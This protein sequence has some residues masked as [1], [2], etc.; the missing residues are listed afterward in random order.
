M[1]LNVLV[2]DVEGTLAETDDVHRAAFNQAFAEARLDWV[3]GRVLYRQLRAQSMPG[4]EV[5]RYVRL[6][7]ADQFDTL[8]ASG[9][10]VDLVQRQRQIYQSLIDAGAAPLRPGV[11]RLMAEALSERVRLAICATTPRIEFVSLIYNR[12]GPDMLNALAASTARED[13]KGQSPIEAYM[14]LLSRLDVAPREVTV[15]EDSGSGTSAAARLGL[16]VIATPTWYSGGDHFGPAH[17]VLSDLGH[18]A[19]PFEVLAG[20]AAGIGHVT[21]SALRYWRMQAKGAAKAA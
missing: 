16:Q 5:D 17:L 13:L 2:F 1:G 12:F 20:H 14:T 6:R 3:W 4:G 10:L 7:L 11:A 21:I 19:A 15:I 8:E 18:P 9:M